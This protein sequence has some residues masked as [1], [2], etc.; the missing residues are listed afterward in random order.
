M[1]TE[2]PQVVVHVLGALSTVGRVPVRVVQSAVVTTQRVATAVITTVLVSRNV[3][4]ERTVPAVYRIVVQVVMV[5]VRQ[6]LLQAVT[7]I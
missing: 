3:A 1:R 7:V 4:V 6:A 2:A 5:P